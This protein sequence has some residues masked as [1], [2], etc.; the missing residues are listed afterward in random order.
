MALSVRAIYEN[1]TL[2]L[3]EPVDL[4]EGQEVQIQL[5]GQDER[6]AVIAALGDLIRPANPDDDRD[7]WVEDM[8]EEIAEALSKGKSLTEI[9]LEERGIP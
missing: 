9:I 2:R 8:A 4:V 5:A 7:A 3:L 1:G 6:A